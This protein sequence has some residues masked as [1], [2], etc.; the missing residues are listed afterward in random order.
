MPLPSG[1]HARIRRRRDIEEEQTG[2]PPAL[3]LW[4]GVYDYPWRGSAFKKWIALSFGGAA[5]GI[6]VAAMMSFYPG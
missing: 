2:P 3:A 1:T 4:T 5:L 6:T